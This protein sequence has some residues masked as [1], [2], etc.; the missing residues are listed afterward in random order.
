MAI[1]SSPILRPRSYHSVADIH[2]DMRRCL[3]L[4]IPYQGR[5]PYDG[6]G[7]D[8]ALVSWLRALSFMA[9]SV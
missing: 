1:A 4:G 7:D 8:F 5:E 6:D 3:T 9:A 2:A